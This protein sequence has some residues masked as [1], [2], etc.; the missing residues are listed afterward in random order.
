MPASCFGPLFH[1]IASDPFVSGCLQEEHVG[2]GEQK[3]QT[4]WGRGVV[5]IGAF[6]S[7]K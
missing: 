3:D 6:A 5:F 4:K 1:C 2:R 7:A